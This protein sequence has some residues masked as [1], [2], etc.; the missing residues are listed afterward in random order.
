[1]A[2]FTAL[3][4]VVATQ[5][6]GQITLPT[7]L[8]A[9]GANMLGGLAPDLDQPTAKIWNGIRGGG[10]LSRLISPLLGGHRFIS[11]SFLGIFLFGFLLDFLLN[12]MAQVL[13]VDMA[14]VWW[15]FMIGYFSHLVMDTLTQEGV[16][17][18]FPI[19]IRFG[20]PPLKFLRI[21]TGGLIEKS[22]VFPGLL[23]LNGYLIYTYY[24]RYLEFLKKYIS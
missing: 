6:L 17:W 19:P 1:M 23:L 15:A 14:V 8:V 12:K 18:L 11:H 5:P 21:K 3:N 20:F 24:G 2:A 10:V 13:I 16:P 7:V 22:F 4:L 9:F